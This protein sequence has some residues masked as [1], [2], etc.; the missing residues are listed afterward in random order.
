MGGH[1]EDGYADDDDYYYD[2]EYDEYEDDPLA[3]L[4]L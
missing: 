1:G 4:G 3:E 2:D